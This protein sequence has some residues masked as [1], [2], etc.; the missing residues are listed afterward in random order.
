MGVTYSSPDS[1]LTRITVLYR[2]SCGAAVSETGVHAAE[3]PP[4]WERLDDERCL[5]PRC[6]EFE[7]RRDAS[8]AGPV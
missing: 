6:V 1:S 8:A 3:P 2:C 5:C 7:R 4:G